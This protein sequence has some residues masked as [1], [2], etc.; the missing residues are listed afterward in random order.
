ME[1]QGIIEGVLHLFSET[2]TEGGDWAFQDARYIEKNVPRGF[3]KKC[4]QWLEKQEGPIQ[5]GRVTLITEEVAEEINRTGKLPE[6]SDCI[7]DAHEEDVGD[8][9]SYEG[10][11]I[12]EDGDRLIIFDKQD[13]QKVIWYGVIQLRQYELFTETT[14]NGMWIHSDQEGVERSV[15]EKFFLEGY[16]AKLDSVS[17]RRMIADSIKAWLH[18]S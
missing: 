8:L 9:W 10:L 2:G 7:N 14:S 4:G 11:H 3:C 16:P 12:L 6:R 13:L 5:V 1:Q 18:R 15:W 17:V